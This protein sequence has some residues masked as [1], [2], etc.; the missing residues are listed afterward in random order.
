MSRPSAEMPRLAA[1]IGWPVAHSLSPLIHMTWAA[2]EGV[3]ARY[4]AIAVEPTDEAFRERI[5]LLREAGYCGVNVTLPHK[6]RALKIA[7][8]ASEAAMTA[9]AANMLTFREG[10]II[11]ANSDATA[12]RALLLDLDP[13][14][15]RG[16]VLGAGGAA[17]GV[18]WALKRAGV[19]TIRI[20]NRTRERAAAIAPIA[21]AKVIDWKARAQALDDVDIL[22]NTTTLGMKG[23]PPLDLDLAAMKESAVVLDI[24][25]A[26]LE[27]PL[28]RNARALGLAVIDGLDML[29]EQAVPAFEAWFG[30]TPTVDAE[31]RA[32]LKRELKSRGLA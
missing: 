29:M 15:R 24:V 11:A 32:I 26:P 22:I 1:V 8:S 14:P 31:L 2:R 27:T 7:D 20:A 12:V 18:L 25:Y 6:E 17:R 10:K 16:L 4:E 21:N 23:A 30:A 19:S 28:L 5:D 9:G 3:D 13:A